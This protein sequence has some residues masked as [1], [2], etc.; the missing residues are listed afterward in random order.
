MIILHI[1]SISNNKCDG[2]CVAVPQ[3]VKAQENNNIVG[4]ININNDRI[5]E[6]DN[7]IQIKYTNK[8]NINNIKEPFNKPDIVIFHGCYRIE[9]LKIAGNLKKNRIP[10]I[11]N[12][13]YIFYK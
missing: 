4:F 6:I 8:F 11:K 13:S 7:N 3:H 5:N 9:Y 12:I 10:Y 2:V 1:A